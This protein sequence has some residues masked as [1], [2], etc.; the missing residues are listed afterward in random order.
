MLSSYPM[1]SSICSIAG[2]SITKLRARSVQRAVCAILFV[3]ASGD[4]TGWAAQV[5]QSPEPGAP[6]SVAV[7]TSQTA[8]LR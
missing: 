4:G 1:I 3:V 5:S 6:A 7:A 2:F 8:V